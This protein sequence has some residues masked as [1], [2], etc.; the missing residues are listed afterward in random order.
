MESFNVDKFCRF[1]SI[2]KHQ[3]AALDPTEFPLRTVEQHNIFLE[4]LED[5]QRQS[6]C[7]V[8][9]SCALSALSYFHPVTGFPP[10]ILHDFFE[11]VVPVELCL[12]LQDLIRKGFITFEGL[13]K[14]IKSFPYKF[15]DNLNKP[16]QITK[17][18]FGTGRVSG[19]GHENWTLLRLLPFIIG[20]RI[21]EHEPSWEVLMDLKELV[22]IVVSTTLSEEILSYLDTKILDHRRLLIETFP[23]FNLKPKHHY[24][25]HYSHLVRCFGP[26]VDLW[27]IRFESK[28]NFFKK[29]VH[30][31]QC[32]K[33]ILLTLSSKHQQMMAYLLDGH[34]LFKPSLHVDN[35]DTVDI[36]F[37]N[38]NLQKCLKLK[39]PQVKAVSFAKCVYLYG[40]QYVKGMII[41]SGQLSGLPEFYKI[42]NILVDSGKVSFVATKL[43][44]WFMEHYRSYR[45]DSSY[46]DLEI[47]DPEDLNDY[48]PLAEYCVDGQLMVTPVTCLLH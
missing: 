32:F 39:Y 29:T 21:P 33:N 4:E 19:N 38:E 48:H 31:V 11:G 7:G 46:K 43:S 40:T 35:I 12:C 23:D 34:S 37:L 9:G 27:T 36:C 41:S 18:S 10:D 1:C 17:A 20:T 16:Q 47:L 30:D 14:R 45:L 2:D 24:I 8:K 44:S 26:L 13:N 6:V 15:S 5:G 22:E 28:H 42:L 3:I 25:E